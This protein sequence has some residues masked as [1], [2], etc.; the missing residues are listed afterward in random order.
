VNRHLCTVL[1]AC[2]ALTLAAGCGSSE[3]TSSST[4]NTTTQSTQSKGTASSS[5]AHKPSGLKTDTTPKFASPSSSEAPKGGTVQI[6]YR[7]IAIDP[8]TVRAKVGSTVKWVNEDSQKCNVTSE[9]GPYKF[10]SGDFGEGK[11]FE[12][13]LTKPGTIHYECTLYPTTMNGTIEVVE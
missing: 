3:S 2:A 6:A 5:K 8:D 11:S 12:L 4:S 7:N 13:K 1:L 9:G 10:S